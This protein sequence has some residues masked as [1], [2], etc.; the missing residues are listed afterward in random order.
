MSEED[1]GPEID[2]S[3]PDRGITSSEAMEPYGCEVAAV[4]ELKA[5]IYRTALQEV[6][7]AFFS[8]YTEALEEEEVDCE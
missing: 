1:F 2:L 8:A 4:V 7:A 5:T 3:F 6:F